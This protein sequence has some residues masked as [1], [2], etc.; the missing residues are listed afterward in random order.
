MTLRALQSSA[1]NKNTQAALTWKTLNVIGRDFG[2]PALDFDRFAARYDQD[3]VLQSLIDK[4][5]KNGIVLRTGNQDAQDLLQHP[6]AGT[7]ELS[8]TAKNA[9]PPELK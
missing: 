3:E 4:F 9:L 7:S 6:E 2:T 5:D 1:N 8:R